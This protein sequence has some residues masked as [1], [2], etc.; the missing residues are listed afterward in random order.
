MA[1]VALGKRIAGILPV[2]QKAALGDFSGKIKIPDKED[3]FTELLVAL[4]LMFDD[5]KVLEKEN[6]EKTRQL[7]KARQILEKEVKE[8]TKELEEKMDELERMNQLM[9]GRELKMIEL[10]KKIADLEKDLKNG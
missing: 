4:S 5:L 3:E 1:E 6:E 2:L 10:K 7:E 9:V 8:R